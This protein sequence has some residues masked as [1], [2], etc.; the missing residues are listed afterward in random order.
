MS[1]EKHVNLNTVVGRQ[2]ARRALRVLH[3]R[4]C[5]ARRAAVARHIARS[6]VVAHQWTVVLH[7]LRVVLPLP[8][9]ATKVLEAGQVAAEVRALLDAASGAERVLQ[10][11]VHLDL[12]RELGRLDLDERGS[13][14]LHVRAVVVE[15]HAA[16]SDGVLE[17]VR[18]DAG[19]QHAS[20]EVVHD[21]CES[22]G[23]EH[24]M[25]GADEDCLLRVEALSGRADVVAVAQHPRDHL[26][27]LG[28]HAAR[29]DLVVPAATVAVVVSARLQQGLHVLLVVE[30]YVHVALGRVGHVVL[31]GPL[32]FDRAE[33][34]ESVRERCLGDV[35]RNAT[36]EDFARVSRVLVRARRQVTAPR[37]GGIAQRGR[38]SVHAGGSL[39]IAVIVG[40]RGHRAGSKSESCG[41]QRG[42]RTLQSRFDCAECGPVGDTRSVQ[43]RG[44]SVCIS[45][46]CLEINQ[47]LAA[48]PLN[49]TRRPPV[50]FEDC[51]SFARSASSADWP[52][53]EDFVGS[54]E[55]SADSGGSCH[56]P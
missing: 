41:V 23:V 39:Q 36:Q 24:A 14:R 48:F 49:Y 34:L 8:A 56:C 10:V 43:Q 44:Q 27:L 32:D 38:V 22:L 33:L 52:A 13:H 54:F 55:E 51:A 29:R 18:V 20:E 6:L 21:V 37:T 12:L 53:L 35:P 42:P 16:G 3:R 31:A 9:R 47:P 5:A 4:R 50:G 46:D 25:Q 28:A 17:F 11:R 7:E 1:R 45:S 40:G 30:D 26:H 19:V 15:R 2:V